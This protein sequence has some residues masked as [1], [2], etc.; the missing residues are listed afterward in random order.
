MEVAKVRR[1]Q[2]EN[3]RRIDTR[4][5]PEPAVEPPGIAAGIRGRCRIE[6]VWRGRRH[7]NVLNHRRR[8]R[9]SSVVCRRWRLALGQLE[10]LEL[11]D[12][13]REGLYLGL[14]RSLA[15]RLGTRCDCWRALVHDAGHA[16]SVGWSQIADI[17]RSGRIDP[18]VDI[19]VSKLQPKRAGENCGQTYPQQKSA[20]Q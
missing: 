14:A 13:L 10:V 5:A 11:A 2:Q 6:G 15:G 18:R 19:R 9:N 8:R 4:K 17:D 12:A 7:D 20:H 16:N 3:T 1:P